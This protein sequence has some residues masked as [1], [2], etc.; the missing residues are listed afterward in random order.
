[1]ID[2]DMVAGH[3]QAMRHGV[4]TITGIRFASSVRRAE[5]ADARHQR[6]GAPAKRVSKL[7]S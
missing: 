2:A 3:D 5:L 4:A 1:M 7:R 6:V